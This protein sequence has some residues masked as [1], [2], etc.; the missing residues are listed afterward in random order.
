MVSNK[1]YNE[2]LRLGEL[3]KS[4]NRQA[5]CRNALLQNE[6]E[7]LN[8][9]YS[10]LAKQVDDYKQKYLDEQHKRLL[11]AERVEVLEGRLKE[12]E[13]RGYVDD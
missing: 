6:N 10:E 4:W 11:L 8:A 7:L 5:W 2:A 12:A 3:F 13:R 1:K 9:K